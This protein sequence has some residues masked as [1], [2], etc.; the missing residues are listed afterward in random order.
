M[1]DIFIGGARGLGLTDL[2]YRQVI[3]MKIARQ[4]QADELTK[5]A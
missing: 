3:Q 4:Q 5:I 2:E 1:L